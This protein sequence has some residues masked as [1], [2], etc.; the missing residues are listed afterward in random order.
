MSDFFKKYIEDK[1]Q[2]PV[3][4]CLKRSGFEGYTQFYDG[5]IYIK[6]STSATAAQSAIQRGLLRGE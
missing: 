6:K 5:E 3:L 1:Q 4:V 2:L